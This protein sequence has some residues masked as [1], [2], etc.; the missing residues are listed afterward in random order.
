MTDDELKEL[1]ERESR[2]TT[3]DARVPAAG[4]VWWR[5]A[6]RARSDAVEAAMRPLVWFHAIVAAAVLGGAAAAIGMLWP[7]IR[8]RAIVEGMGGWTMRLVA[9]VA[10]GLMAVTVALYF[11]RGE[12][13]SD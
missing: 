3:E 9:I 13:R 11:A 8:E 6:M 2:L 12:R 10:A 1:F 5:A 7:A 4:A